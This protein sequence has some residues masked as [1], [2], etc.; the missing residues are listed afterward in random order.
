MSVPT[1]F[2]LQ[3]L[4]FNEEACIEFLFQE[5]IFYNEMTC[6]DCGRQLTKNLQRGTWRCG[7]KDCRK[8]ISI[9]KDSFF[10]RS[11]LPCSRIL[12]FGYL[13]LQG[14]KPHSIQKMMGVSPNTVADFN[15]FYRQLTIDSL[16]EEDTKIGGP[17]IVVEIDEAKLGKCK[18]NRGHPVNGVWVLGGVERTPQRKVFLTYV[19]K[20]DAPTLLSIIS[21]HV[22]EGTIIYTDMWASYRDLEALGF[23]H[24][25]V[26][27]SL[28]FR[29]PETGV[30]TN[31]IEGTWNG[32]KMFI[33]R[34]NRTVEGVNDHLEEF[35][36][37]RRNHDRLWQALLEC[38]K[39]IKY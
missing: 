4:F 39:E 26:N 28:Y 7:K 10:A 6:P 30:H 27:H 9:R 19:E 32:V 23:R 1:I 31:T 8:E 35:I 37:R 34:R 13:W 17:G 22:L 15:N 14:V 2:Q 5:G 11:H 24:S 18:Y 29:H 38:L 20:R 25:T 21:Q 36:W 33:A 3:H 12:F 16:E